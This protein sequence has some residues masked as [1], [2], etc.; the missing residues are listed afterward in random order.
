MIDAEPVLDVPLSRPVTTPWR[1]LGAFAGP[2]LAY[3][4]LLVFLVFFKDL[5]WSRIIALIGFWTIIGTSW[6]II[7]GYAGQPSFGHSAFVGVGAY[8]TVILLNAG[9]IPWIGAPC[10]I[11][12]ACI[13]ALLIGYPTLRLRDV[14]FALAT[15]V[16]PL[17]LGLIVT[18]LELQE[19][20]VPTHPEAQF[21]Y[22]SWTDPR[23]FAALF[24]LIALIV[25]IALTLVERSRYRL[26]LEAIR[27]DEETAR[28][29]GINTP[30]VKLVC[31][32]AS[33]ALAALAGA[34]YI[35]LI[36]VVTPNV[37]SFDLS[38]QAI[39]IALVGG[40]GRRAGGLIGA[41]ILVPIANLTESWFGTTSGGSQLAYG[42][43][44]MVVVVIMPRGIIDQL[45]R[46]LRSVRRVPAAEGQTGAVPPDLRVIEGGKAS[47][48]SPLLEGRGLGKSYG[49]I[50]AVEGMDIEVARGEFVGLVG[51]NGA[52]KSTLFDLL[53]GYQRPNAGR[54][55]I[56]GADVTKLPSYEI[57][58][59]GVRRTFQS[60]RPFGRLSV[61]ENVLVGSAASASAAPDRVASARGALAAVGLLGCRDVAASSLTP[62]QLRLLEVARAIVSGPDLLLLDE[63]LAGLTA[64]ETE[65]LL[66]VL[67]S[68]NEQGLSIL[69]VDHNVGSVAQAVSRL[70]VIDRGVVIAN[71]APARVMRD[72]RVIRAY[73]GAGA[74]AA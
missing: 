21:L 32:V 27:Q 45:E 52:G 24:G 3:A 51:P 55:L 43:A 65:S 74:H 46:L 25:W 15:L 60:A 17:I 28:S 12:V 20:L 7:G 35:Q 70:V 39:L 57:A 41:A 64:A 58:R 10:A 73:L 26:L 8:T 42:L 4:A 66:N 63:P 71:A 14:Y 34:I 31:F 30:R 23:W 54:V 48:L 33:A 47:N 22:M 69:I 38:I 72:E 1:T 61:L 44:L 5:Y 13:A 36:F 18:Y 19:V 6:N 9:V 40:I 56:A 49:G 67:R 62:S 68:L 50:V 11:G 2:V 37:L 53:T 16:Y 29:A 59:R